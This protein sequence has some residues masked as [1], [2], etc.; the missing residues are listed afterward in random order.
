MFNHEDSELSR[1]TTDS[2][3]AENLESVLAICCFT[4]RSLAFSHLESIE[5]NVCLICSNFLGLGNRS[6][7]KFLELSRA[8]FSKGIE[9]IFVLLSYEL[10]K[11]A[12][13][14][15]VVASMREK[16]DWL[17]RENHEEKSYAYFEQTKTIYLRDSCH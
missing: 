12:F 7:V 3:L 8:T 9:F 2:R 10:L 4:N 14:A 11:G 1:G 17:G 13:S 6:T 15:F 5:S 16:S